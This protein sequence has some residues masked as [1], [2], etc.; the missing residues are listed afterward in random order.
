MENLL[1]LTEVVSQE[2]IFLR[3]GKEWPPKSNLLSAFPF[4]SVNLITFYDRQGGNHF[5]D[6]SI[7][8]SIILN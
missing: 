4:V 1:S 2:E 6:L 5:R 8:G 7:D 3:E